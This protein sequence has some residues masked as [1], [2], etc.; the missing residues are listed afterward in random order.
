MKKFR[1]PK[2]SAKIIASKLCAGETLSEKESA[3]MFASEKDTT[4][5]RDV[6]RETAQGAQGR[7]HFTV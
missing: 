3:A 2:I 7:A 4:L 6:A 1:Q 5:A